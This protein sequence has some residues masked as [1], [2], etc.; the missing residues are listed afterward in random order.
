MTIPAKTSPTGVPAGARSAPA[1]ASSAMG[2]DI[3][4]VISGSTSDVAISE[5]SKKGFKQVKVLNQAVITKLITEAVDTVIA[6]RSQKI[7]RDEREKVIQES[8][9]QFETLARERIKRERDRIAELERANEALLKET[10]DLRVGLQKRDQELA[11]LK[12]DPGA[13]GGSNQLLSALMEKLQG[14]GAGSDLGKLESSIQ[15]IAEK[16]DRLPASGGGGGLAYVDKDVVIDALF[17]DDPNQKAE[18]N[19]GH[20][21]IKQ[22]KA[23]GV[24][25]TLAK[26]KALQ[27]GGKDG[28]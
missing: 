19:I 5:L 26:L 13:A 11:R 22:E 3:K 18:S 23:G 2:L 12:T 28:D 15:K 10:E 16:L 25:D 9:G 20:V 17:R 7:G 14:S 1:P 27:K 4:R 21:K 24:K 8:E 6:A